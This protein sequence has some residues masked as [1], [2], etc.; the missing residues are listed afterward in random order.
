MS[1]AIATETDLEAFV[2]A[3]DANWR[4]GGPARAFVERFTPLLD[5]QVRLVQP[6]V[7]TLVGLEAFERGFAEPLFELMPDARGAVRKWAGSGDL[8]YVEV[9]VG[10]CIGGRKVV[11]HSCDRLT[12]RDGRLAE[13]VA[14]LDPSPLVKAVGLSPRAWPTFLRSQLANRRR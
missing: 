10:G 6:Q 7:P 5:P 4:Q 12:L 2:E 9:D 11:L 14:F 1:E 8:V 3:F 13:R